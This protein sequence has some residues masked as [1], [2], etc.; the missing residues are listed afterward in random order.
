MIIDFFRS[1]FTK[2]MIKHDL[3]YAPPDGLFGGDSTYV[4]DYRRFGQHQPAGLIK[5]SN[6]PSQ[7]NE[8]FIDTTSHKE[9]Y[10]RHTLP[11]KFYKAKEEYKRNETIEIVDERKFI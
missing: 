1:S 5:P 4:N 7:S 11:A 8:P 9:D 10:I 2:N 6:G 3:S